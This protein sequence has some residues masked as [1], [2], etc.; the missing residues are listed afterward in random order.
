MTNSGNAPDL[1]LDLLRDLLGTLRHWKLSLFARA[2]FI[3][4]SLKERS[5]NTPFAREGDGLPFQVSEGNIIR[6]AIGFD[7]FFDD[8]LFFFKHKRSSPVDKIVLRLYP[9]PSS[10]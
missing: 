4:C 5:G 9:S 8:L 1:R 6:C 10:P 3:G 2:C 7:F